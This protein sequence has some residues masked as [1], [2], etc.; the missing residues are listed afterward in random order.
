LKSVTHGIVPTA[1][2]FWMVGDLA[3]TTD[4]DPNSCGYAH[5]NKRGDDQSYLQWDLGSNY[6]LSS[7]TFSWGSDTSGYNGTV[8]L[9]TSPDGATWT[10]QFIKTM[11]TLSWT[12]FE[13]S[14]GAVNNVRYIRVSVYVDGGDHFFHPCELTAYGTPIVEYGTISI[15]SEPVYCDVFIDDVNIGKTPI[16]NY[17]I[18]SGGHT[19][20][21]H[22][23]ETWVDWGQS[24]VIGGGE[25]ID[26][27]TVS[28][29]SAIRRIYGW[30][31][32]LSTGKG[33]PGA[34]VEFMYD[35]VTTDLI[36]WYDWKDPPLASGPITA[37]AN[38]YYSETQY[39]T[40]P[41]EGGLRV[42]FVLR[43]IYG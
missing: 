7:I 24:F 16:E 1:T 14:V 20:R 42:S 11:N 35:Y 23:D 32:D 40:S 30:V 18:P 2:G 29:S 5:S 15:D 28:L 4:G 37:S 27:G 25:H 22:K 41:T 39:I 10:T 8:K 33:I 31:I 12:G 17:S 21:V 36:G 3:S 38:N 13:E 6:D 19:I 34:K 43:P 9:K 26:F